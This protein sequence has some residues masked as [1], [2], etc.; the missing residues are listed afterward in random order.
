MYSG[1]TTFCSHSFQLV[2]YVILFYE[3]EFF[4]ANHVIQSWHLSDLGVHVI[5][6]AIL[7]F[8]KVACESSHHILELNQPVSI[9]CIRERQEFWAIVF[10]KAHPLQQATHSSCSRCLCRIYLS[11]LQ[12]KQSGNK[13]LQGISNLQEESLQFSILEEISNDLGATFQWSMF[14]N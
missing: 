11:T 2:F 9:P 7:G 14:Q 4:K 5:E 10:Q 13:T 12:T 3:F 8:L 6:R 1:C